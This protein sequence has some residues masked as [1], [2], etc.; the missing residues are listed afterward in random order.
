MQRLVAPGKLPNGSNTFGA[1]ELAQ[2]TQE[3]AVHVG[4]LGLTTT[5]AMDPSGQN[6]EAPSTVNG[7]TKTEA[8]YDY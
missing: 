7:G 4:K 6:T 5:Q 3:K 8:F 2:I 1:G